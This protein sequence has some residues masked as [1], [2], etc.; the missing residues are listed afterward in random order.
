MLL[1]S[2]LRVGGV[3]APMGQTVVVTGPELAETI[4]TMVRPLGVQV[5]VE[6][7]ARSTGPCL[8]WVAAWIAS[9]DP[10]GV[11]SVFP[12]DHIVREVEAFRGLAVAAAALAQRSDRIVT[13]GIQPDHPATGYGYI[14]V[15]EIYEGPAHH[16]VGFV[17]KPDRARALEYLSSGSYVW[18]A[19]MFFMRVGVLLEAVRRHQPGWTQGL[20]DSVAD[21]GGVG[22]ER[23]FAAVESVSVDVAIMEPEGE[24]LLVI[25]ARVGWCDL[26]SWSTLVE[27]ANE[28]SN[29][30]KGSARL[31]DVDRSVIV[32]EAARVT[33]LG[34]SDL[35]VVA[36]EDEILVAALDRAE[37]VRGLA[38]LDLG[39]D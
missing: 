10:D 9:Q 17:E 11:M 8:A 24:R 33:V 2:I 29:F 28:G 36:T 1:E 35:C 37:E 27:F 38:D 30:V 39:D 5:L 6:P 3:V 23:F 32:S 21:D 20:A 25:P 16:A 13:L 4:R 18:N 26:G 22:L 12:A 15:G 19:G 7:A 14:R 34:L 31:V